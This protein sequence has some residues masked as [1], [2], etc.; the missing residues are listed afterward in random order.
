M[1]DNTGDQGLGSPNMSEEEKRAIQ[2]AGGSASGA[3][4][5]KDPGRAS[6]MGKKGGSQSRRSR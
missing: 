6:R 3:N 5:K 2:S 1:A 4:F